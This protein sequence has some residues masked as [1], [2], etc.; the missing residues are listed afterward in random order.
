MNKKT[1]CTP[2]S[3]RRRRRGC[4]RPRPK[5]VNIS[6]DRSGSGPGRAPRH[7]LNTLK[8][9]IA[10]QNLRHPA[11]SGKNSPAG[12]IRRLGPDPEPG[13]R[14]LG[15]GPGPRARAGPWPRPPGPN[16]SLWARGPGPRGQPEFFRRPGHHF[17]P[18]DFGPIRALFGR[19]F[20][21]P[22]STSGSS[23]FSGQFRS[24]IGYIGWTFGTP[25]L[26]S[27][28]AQAAGLKPSV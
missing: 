28:L 9:L 25:G 1:F 12:R 18:K 13:P 20:A 8:W 2:A 22:S 3:N 24:E 11:G 21:K 27:H 4:S 23:C 6:L 7:T 17:S 15:P 10:H 14:A 16:F 5:R 26:R 19:I